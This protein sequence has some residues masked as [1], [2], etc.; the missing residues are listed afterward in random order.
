M[1]IGAGAHGKVSLGAPRRH[2]AHREAET[3]ARLSG[4]RQRRAWRRIERWRELLAA[5]DLPFEFMLN[6][7]RL[8]DGF[9]SAAIERAHRTW[10]ETL[11]AKAWPGRRSAACS[12]PGR[13]AGG[14]RNLGRRFLNDLQA[15][16]LA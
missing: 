12:K 8:N 11:E 13:T 3:A 1:G 6:A 7:L 9:S 16:F 10:L 14:R 15:S 2:R 5:R 4:T